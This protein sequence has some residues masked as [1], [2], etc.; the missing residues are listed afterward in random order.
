MTSIAEVASRIP[1]QAEPIEQIGARIGVTEHDVRLFTRLFGLRE[2][3]VAHDRGYTD[4]L[5]DAARELKTLRGN[6]SRVKY[7]MVARTFRDIAPQTEDPVG[8]IAERLGLDDA[9][10]FAVTEHACASGLLALWTAGWLLRDEE[11]GSL[12]LIL[13][14][15]IPPIDGFYLPST[16]IMG[17]SSAACLVGAEG[18]RDRLLSYSFRMNPSID[19]TMDIAVSHAPD[20]E[21]VIN[22]Y[23]EV[24]SE[25]LRKIYIDEIATVIAEAVEQAGI[26]M[27][28]LALILPHNVNRIS[29]VRICRRI[30]YPV[31]KVMT[32]LI[33]ITGHC[34][35]ADG[36]LNYGEAR[37]RDLLRPGDHYLIVG[38]GTG[39]SFAAMAFQR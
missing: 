3:R 7:L 17:D 12:A 5:V 4:R 8:E 19:Q 2:V 27:D 30:G 15:E 20:M 38:V 25:S 18:E 21:D 24:S 35:T 23:S 11:P 13:T 32:D 16:T 34:Y 14:G 9:V 39:G 10:G 22:K 37:R 29:W 33:P 28:D 31:E 1:E 36:F 6:E 26:G